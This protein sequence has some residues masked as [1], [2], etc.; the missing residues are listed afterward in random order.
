[1]PYKPIQPNS[2]IQPNTNNSIIFHNQSEI[3]EESLEKGLGA[4][5]AERLEFYAWQQEKLDRKALDE[6]IAR[7][8]NTLFIFLIGAS[9]GCLLAGLSVIVENYQQPTSDTCKVR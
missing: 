8:Y 6:K 5:F 1:M 9:F 3:W 7:W 2:K 4:S